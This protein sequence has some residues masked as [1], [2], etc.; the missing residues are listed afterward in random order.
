MLQCGQPS[1]VLSRGRPAKFAASRSIPVSTTLPVAGH[2]KFNVAI[3]TPLGPIIGHRERGRYQSDVRGRQAIGRSYFPARRC[4]GGN[5]AMIFAHL[6]FAL[7]FGNPVPL[8]SFY[9]CFRSRTTA[10]CFIVP[11]R[12][13]GSIGT[14]PKHQFLGPSPTGARRSYFGH[15]RILTARCDEK[16]AQSTEQ[17]GAGLCAA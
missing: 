14:L 5:A 13:L 10:D 1:S 11:I 12:N 4:L 2:I 3:T 16:I 9:C 17:N 15:Q 7:S 6:I 8:G